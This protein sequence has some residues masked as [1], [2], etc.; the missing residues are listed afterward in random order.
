MFGGFDVGGPWSIHFP[1]EDDRSIKCY[2][3]IS[4]SCWLIVDGMDEPVRFDAGD[5]LVLATERSFRITTDPALPPVDF[6]TI[7][8]RPLE[9]RMLVIDGGGD[10]V[11]VGGY[12]ALGGPNADM[13]LDLLPP[14]VHLHQPSDRASLRW[15][16]DQMMAELRDPQ[17]GG[18]L[19]AEHI[20]HMMLLVALRLHLAAGAGERV[21]WLFALA[22]AQMRPA[23]EAMHYD[24]AYRWTLNE[25]AQRA[26]MSRSAFA[27]KFKTTVGSAPM[28][29]L[30]RWRMLVACDRLTHSR[31]SVS[32]IALALGYESESAFS[33]AFKRVMGCSP[34]SYV[35]ELEAAAA[36]AV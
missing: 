4:G 12:F 14:V 27:V 20:L 9:G 7:V 1:Q 21:G 2:A 8:T 35:R 11:G 31:D 5:C 16:L 6:Y 28:E 23:I 19:I 32:K 18:A 24:L 36:I 26:S 34:R 10:L 29:Y 15:S 22:D 33:T 13:L 17:P 3:L 30:T 25:L